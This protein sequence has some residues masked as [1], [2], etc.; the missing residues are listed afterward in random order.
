MDNKFIALT[1]EIYAYLEDKRSDAPD[2]LL[3]EL[4]R[5]TAALGD[6]SAMQIAPEQGTFLRI[7]AG[8]S[9]AQRAL[10]IGTFTGYSSLCIARGLKEDASLTCLDQSGDWTQIARKFWKR[11]G[12]ESRID[13]RLG[14]AHE[15]LKALVTEGSTFDFVF[16]DADKTGY[17]EYFETLVPHLA[18]DA[19]LIFDNM[20]RGGR[21]AQNS[22]TTDD[23]IALDALNKK[24]ARDERVESVL[25]AVADGLMICRF[26]GV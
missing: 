2:G 24:L 23:D 4:R 15:T 5:E 7:L 25:L 11:A 21:L 10:E 12:V 8:V 13:L 22:L 1:P 26:K 9:G 14:D 17:D 19:L 16:I 20:L 3:A 18:P 6:I